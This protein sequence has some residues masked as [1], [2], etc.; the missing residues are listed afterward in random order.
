MTSKCLA[1]DRL[2]VNISLGAGDAQA[3]RGTV[4]KAQA[5]RA[6][7]LGWVI[8]LQQVL[9]VCPGHGV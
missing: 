7:S 9:A 2:L 6:D 3:D 8:W 1:H 5:F 4:G